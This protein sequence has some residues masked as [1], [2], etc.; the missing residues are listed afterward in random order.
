MTSAPGFQSECLSV[1]SEK[2]S[3]FMITVF[4]SRSHTLTNFTVIIWCKILQIRKLGPIDLLIGRSQGN[5]ICSVNLF[6]KS[7]PDLGK[8]NNSI[9][10]AP[11]FTSGATY[12]VTE[13]FVS[14]CVC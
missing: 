9:L 6:R 2:V 5:D 14:V 7:L 8:Y 11:R 13:V 1:Q 12:L 10:V 4:F 3:S